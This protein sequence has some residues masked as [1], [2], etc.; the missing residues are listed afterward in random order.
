MNWSELYYTNNGFY[1]KNIMITLLFRKIIIEHLTI[2]L[3][4]D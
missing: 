4:H 1:N 3:K 2:Y